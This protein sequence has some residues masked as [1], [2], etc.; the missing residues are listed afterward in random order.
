VLTR[1]SSAADLDIAAAAAAQDAFAPSPC[2]K[3]KDT[4]QPVP[5]PQLLSG[6]K[7]P[8]AKRTA[9]KSRNPNR[10]FYACWKIGTYVSFLY[11]MSY[12][13][14]RMILQFVFLDFLHFFVLVLD[15]VR[16]LIISIWFLTQ[17]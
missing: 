12:N 17:E 10:E 13:S 4:I 9:H 15:R 11:P 8:L 1:P 7:V 16:L 6:C 3:T 5:A 14:I 2:A